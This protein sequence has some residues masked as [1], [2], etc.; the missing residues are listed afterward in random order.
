MVKANFNFFGTQIS[1]HEDMPK[2][3]NN[4]LQIVK[5]KTIIEIGTYKGG[6]SVLFQLYSISSNCRFVT[7]DVKDFVDNKILFKY[8]NINNKLL[9]VFSDDAHK[10]ISSLLNNIGVSVLFCDGGDKVK[11][12]NFFAKYL[13]K[14]DYIFAH[15]YA[16]NKEY[17]N[18]N[19]NNK[20][21]NWCGIEDNNVIQ[22]VKDNN[23]EKTFLEFENVATLCMIKK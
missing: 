16:R 15:D 4:F 7:Y 10:E 1:Q 13:K 3:L 8:L 22:T 2:V 11:E 20:I 19:I 12:F 6:L 17:F 9:N 23:L 5:P 18:E 21:W 14:G